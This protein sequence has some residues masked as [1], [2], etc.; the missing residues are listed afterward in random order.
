M[1]ALFVA[2]VCTLLV[3]ASAPALSYTFDP[4]VVTF[5]Q[6]GTIVDATGS[7]EFD[8]A[9]L[10]Q[11]TVVNFDPLIWPS[12]GRNVLGGSA[13]ADVYALLIPPISFGGGGNEFASASSGPLAGI[14]RVVS[15]SFLVVPVGYTSGTLLSESDTFAGATFA[16]LGL[17]PG[18]YTWTWGNEI[19]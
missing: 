2:A 1:K 12:A 10:T 4:Y 18:T 3:G 11:T 5:E 7:G 6:V 16:S 17:T 19:D 9:G 14:Y 15:S 8:I 13:S